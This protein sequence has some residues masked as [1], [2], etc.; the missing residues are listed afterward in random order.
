[1]SSSGAEHT[2][3]TAAGSNVSAEATY[4]SIKTALKDVIDRRDV[5]VFLQGSYANSTNIRAD[6]DV[7]VVVMT[8]QVFQGRFESLSPVARARWDAIP[9][10]TYQSSNLRD[11]VNKA[12]VDYYGSARVHPKNKCIRVDKTSGYVDADV[13]PCIQYRRFT[14]NDPNFISD[15]IEGIAITPLQGTRIINYPKS[16]IKNGQEKNALCLARFKPT[17][18][19]LKRLRNRAIDEARLSNEIAPGYLLECMTYNAPADHFPDGDTLRLL[20]VV[21]WLKGADKQQFW[22]CDGIHKLFGDDPGKFDIATA[23][24]IVDALWDAL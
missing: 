19:Q 6:S 8:K 13:V 23:Q 17:V 18:R 16:H 9:D 20:T 12:L 22:S 21:Q 2:A 10:S 11:E 1:M 7:D 3:W 24:H 4:K 15:F 14:S 5:E